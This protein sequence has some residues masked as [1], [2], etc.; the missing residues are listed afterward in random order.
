MVG[1]LGGGGVHYKYLL[2]VSQICTVQYCT[3]SNKMKQS[4]LRSTEQTSSA[5]STQDTVT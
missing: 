2:L 1:L 4:S 5:P 3:N